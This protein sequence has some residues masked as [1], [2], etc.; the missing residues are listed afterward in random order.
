[1]GLSIYGRRW[2]EVY[3]YPPTTPFEVPVPVL[4]ESP[5]PQ[6][7]GRFTAFERKPRFFPT[8]TALANPSQYR[9]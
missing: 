4:A 9:V 2:G 7:R 3:F 5:H 8:S 6:S 1:M